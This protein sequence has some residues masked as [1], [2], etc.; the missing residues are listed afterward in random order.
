MELPCVFVHLTFIFRMSI[1]WVRSDTVMPC[2]IVFVGCRKL[3]P[4]DVPS[5][6]AVI[7]Q[8]SVLLNVKTVVLHLWCGEWATVFKFTSPRSLNN[9]FMWTVYFRWLSELRKRLRG[10]RPTSSKR[11]ASVHCKKNCAI[12]LLFGTHKNWW[13]EILLQNC[14]FFHTHN[15]PFGKIS[16][17]AFP[18]LYH[19]SIY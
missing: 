10:W 18:F 2:N 12:V 13:K 17:S 9:F 15:I 4:F 14:A 11:F 1:P 8:S 16:H 3:A 5:V 7:Y 6:H 19:F